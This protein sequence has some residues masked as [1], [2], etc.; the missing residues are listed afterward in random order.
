[1]HKKIS[2][3]CS[4]YLAWLHF[5]LFHIFKLFNRGFHN[6]FTRGER[7]QERPIGHHGLALSLHTRV[8]RGHQNLFVTKFFL[9]FN[10]LSV[11]DFLPIPKFKRQFYIM[12]IWKNFQNSI[13]LFIASF[14]SLTYIFSKILWK[15]KLI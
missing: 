6:F 14:V 7:P 5:F 1:M 9:I 11:G 15:M 13:F 4:K 8:A 12:M 10:I 2:S 3:I